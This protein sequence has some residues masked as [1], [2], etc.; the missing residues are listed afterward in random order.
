[1]MLNTNAALALA[2]MVSC[3]C[4]SLE[5]STITLSLVLEVTR[6]YGGFF[7][8]PKQLTSGG[9]DGW[10]FADALSYLKYSFVGT[11]VNEMSGLR[12]AARTVK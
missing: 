10:K 9:Y 4:V 11:A 3:L 2:T 1:M 6:L 7:T 12:C 5:L 8:S